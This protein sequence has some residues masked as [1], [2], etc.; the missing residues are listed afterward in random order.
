MVVMMGSD[1][2]KR[3]REEQAKC[4]CVNDKGISRKLFILVTVLVTV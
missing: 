1:S 3:E 2:C 4:S